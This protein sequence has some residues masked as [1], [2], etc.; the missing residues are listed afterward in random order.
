MATAPAGFDELVEKRIAALQ[1]PGSPV[2]KEAELD[3]LNEDLQFRTQHELLTLS[4]EFQM[5]HHKLGEWYVPGTWFFARNRAQRKQIIGYFV[6]QIFELNGVLC[7]LR[8]YGKEQRFRF[9]VAHRPVA[10]R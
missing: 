5:Q 7:T 8:W 10:S 1:K 4:L 3:L 2:E 9:E 6:R